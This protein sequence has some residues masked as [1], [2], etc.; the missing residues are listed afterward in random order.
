[1]IQR[2]L[3]LILAL[4][5]GAAAAQAGDPPDIDELEQQLRDLSDKNDFYGYRSRAVKKLAEMG[6]EEAWTLVL[7]ALTD[8]APRVRDEAQLRLG[9]VSDAEIVE[10]LLLGKQ[11]LRSKEPWVRLRVAEALGRAP[12]TVEAGPLAKALSDKDAAVRRAVCWT[13]ERRAADAGSYPDGTE[14]LETALAK[15]L[16]RDKDHLVRGAALLALEALAPSGRE[17]GALRSDDEM[18]RTAAAPLAAALDDAV[19]VLAGAAEDGS[20]RVRTSA[21]DALADLAS[22]QATRILV[23]RLAAEPELRLRWRLVEHL[24]RLSGLMHGLNP[25]PWEAWAEGLADDWAPAE[26]VGEEQQELGDRSVTFAGL[27]ILSGRVCFLVD[28][29][30]SLWMERDDGSTRKEVVDGELRRAL[31]S[32]PADTLF[33]VIPYTDDPHPWQDEL[34]PATK[35]NV[36]KALAWFEGCKKKGKGNVYSAFELALADPAVDTIVVLTDGAPSGGDRWNLGLMVD[37]LAEENRFRQV[38]FDAVLVDTSKAL[39]RYWEDL[40]RRTG[41]RTVAIEL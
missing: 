9:Q 14:K 36:G 23:V 26:E 28:F 4:P 19:E 10:D 13:V 8:I 30:G 40:A 37:L 24:R 11:G 15:A 2:L 3:L 12:S 27:P 22:A 32:L 21:A 41:G 29:S 1:M 38:A 31:E 20:W 34:V 6:G 35:R 39:R 16:T 5:L 18:V 25:S 33:N 7:G 17:R